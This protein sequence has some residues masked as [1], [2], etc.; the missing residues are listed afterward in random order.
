MHNPMPDGRHFGNV[1][2][3]LYQF[4]KDWNTG[5]MIECR[6]RISLFLSLS[7][8]RQFRIGQP[9]AFKLSFHQP[10]REPGTIEKS[11]L[12]AR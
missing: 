4:G 7:R 6:D 10:R 2:M 3:S 11:K 8:D 12:Q 9:D 1:H 5:D